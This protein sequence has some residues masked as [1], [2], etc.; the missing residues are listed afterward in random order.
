MSVRS[1]IINVNPESLSNPKIMV[2]TLPYYEWSKDKKITYVITY[3]RYLNCEM[4]CYN[5]YKNDSSFFET[6]EQKEAI[7][8]LNKI[9]N[10][11]TK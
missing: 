9:L 7:N 5:S 8:H 10:Q 1:I 3:G 2:G 6:N 4:L 11:I